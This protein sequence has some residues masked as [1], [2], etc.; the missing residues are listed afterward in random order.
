M[1]LFL[2]KSGTHVCVMTS[3][4]YLIQLIKTGS[5]N[6]FFASQQGYCILL[7]DF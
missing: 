4:E 5:L 2:E 7:D 1:L 3:I 6:Q